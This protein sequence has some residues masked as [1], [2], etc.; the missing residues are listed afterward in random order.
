MPGR[1]WC[2][3]VRAVDMPGV[4]A[5]RRITDVP[6]SKPYDAGAD[7]QRE[8]LCL[9]ASRKAAAAGGDASSA[10]DCVAAAAL[11]NRCC[12]RET[13]VGRS[14]GGRGGTAADVSD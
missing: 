12:G 11:E 1:G 8:A 5:L 4:L 6:L 9:E 14:G 13:P 3:L 10:S 2:S 7:T